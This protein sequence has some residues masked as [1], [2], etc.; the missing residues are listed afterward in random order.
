MRKILL[1]SVVFIVSVMM[2]FL[3]RVQAQTTSGA[4]DWYE[5]KLK[6]CQ[7]YIK[8]A[9]QWKACMKRGIDERAEI[10][11]TEHVESLPEKNLKELEKSGYSKEKAKELIKGLL[12]EAWNKTVE[13]LSKTHLR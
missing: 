12:I 4:S 13:D 7:E 9:S 6:E 1:F 11:A 3:G 8:D 10:A 5:Y 2:F